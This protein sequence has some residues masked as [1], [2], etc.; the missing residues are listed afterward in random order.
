MAIKRRAGKRIKK[1]LGIF[2]D[3]DCRKSENNLNQG[4]EE[5]G[6][7]QES[8]RGKF[9]NELISITGYESGN[10]YSLLQKLKTEGFLS[11]EWEP[12]EEVE[13]RPLRKYYNITAEGKKFFEE[14]TSRKD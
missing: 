13:A 6:I 3:Y 8:M 9:A 14:A 2:Y 10:L 12:Y 7:V 5:K 1:V 11:V 4:D